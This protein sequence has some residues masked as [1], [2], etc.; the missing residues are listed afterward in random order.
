LDVEEAYSHSASCHHSVQWHVRS[1]GWCDVSFGQ[2]EDSMEGRLVLR[3]EVSLTEAFQI[4]RRSHSND[5]HAPDSRTHPWSFPEIV[6]IQKV[7]QGN[8]Y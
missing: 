1:H 6:I 2:E 7:G 4:L 3:C 5:G 8:R